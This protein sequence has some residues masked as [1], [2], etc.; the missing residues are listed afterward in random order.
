MGAR[1]QPGPRHVPHCLHPTHPALLGPDTGRLRA[2][3]GSWSRASPAPPLL[4]RRPSALLFGQELEDLLGLADPGD[5]PGSSSPQDGERGPPGA[6]PYPERAPHSGWENG[7]RPQHLRPGGTRVPRT[8]SPASRR[9]LHFRADKGLPDPEQAVCCRFGHVMSSGRLP[10]VV[11]R[12][13]GP[14][15]P[16]GSGDGRAAGCCWAPSCLGR[17]CWQGPAAGG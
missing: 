16:A 14:Q 17:G 5:S 8:V 4:S 11:R 2:E 6:S 3:A 13:K 12:E 15:R 9:R 7:N 1:K 10:G